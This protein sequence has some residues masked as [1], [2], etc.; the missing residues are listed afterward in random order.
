[1]D[2]WI[3]LIG[4]TL[5]LQREQDNHV[6]EAAVAVVKDDGVVVGHVPANL[7][8]IVFHFLSRDGN[9]ALAEITGNKVNRGAGYGLEVPCVYRFYGLQQHRERLHKLISDLRRK[10]LV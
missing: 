4:E 9:T 10:G 1:M 6:D 2:V 5:T 7:A 8:S 3:P